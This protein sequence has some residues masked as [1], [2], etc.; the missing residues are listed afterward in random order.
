[1]IIIDHYNVR[2]HNSSLDY[3]TPNQAHNASGIIK[4]RCKGYPRQKKE[5]REIKL[6][7]FEMTF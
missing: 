2:R 4:K 3:L 1:M 6:K 5:S 7:L